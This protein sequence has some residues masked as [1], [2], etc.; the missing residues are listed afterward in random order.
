M[1]SGGTTCSADEL[2][3]ATLDEL[4]R[5]VFDQT[6]NSM[7]A[8]KW[9][10]NNNK[11]DW[12]GSGY[13]LRIP[14]RIAKN[15]SAGKT[16]GYK[17]LITTPV[18]TISEVTYQLARYYSSIT[19][20]QDLKD[21]NRGNK[22]AVRL[23]TDKLDEGKL[24]INDLI[25][26]D[27]FAASVATDAIQSLVTTIDATGIAGNLNQSTQSTWAAYETSMGSFSAGGL[28]YM[29]LAFNT[30]SK[31]R[32]SGSPSL[33]ITTQTVF[34]YYQSLLR[35]YGMDAFVTKGDLGI[36]ELKFMGASVIWDAAAASA[37]MLFLN[38]NA[39]GLVIDGEAN[40][41]STEFVKPADQLAYVG[42]IYTRLQLVCR[43]RRA[44]GKLT[45]ITA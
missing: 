34:Q 11:I 10:Q 26:A 22:A 40:M 30:V 39:L 16:S 12:D 6:F 5:K 38:S 3:V 37:T 36:T 32:E 24:A 14:I 19:Y 31:G 43:E 15:T 28:D 29:Q 7:P 13:A 27:I 42:Q 8:L 20:S 2:I 35:S 4:G 44:L 21:I 1:A 17:T 45:G 41:K 33:I 23:I 18:T 25:A 9:L